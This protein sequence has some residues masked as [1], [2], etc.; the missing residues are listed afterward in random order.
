MGIELCAIHLPRY[1]VTLWLICLK[2]Q[3]TIAKDGSAHSTTPRV[4]SVPK[5]SVTDPLGVCSIV[6]GETYAITCPVRFRQDMQIVA[7]AAR[8]FFANDTNYVALTEVRLND[9]DG[10]SA[11]NIDIVLAALNEQGQV[12]DFGAIEVQAVYITG[13]ISNVFKA[14]MKAPETSFGLEWPK[15]NYPKPDYLSSSRKRLAP[16][17]IYKGGILHEWG[18]K[19][20]VGVH[21]A[22][23]ATLP[24]LQEV[25]AQDAEIAWLV[26][27]LARERS[28]NQY[29][30]ALTHIRYTRFNEALD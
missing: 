20:A 16:Q 10:N 11:G 18:K 23:F 14:Y 1:L 5:K 13:N 6:A 9:K 4:C 24:T 15:K 8:F 30:L 26:Y 17:L 25:D 28:T 21:S 3:S 7:D 19:I 12:V 2:R 22:F 27:D 29:R